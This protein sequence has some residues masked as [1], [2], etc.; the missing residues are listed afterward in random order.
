MIS[1]LSADEI[2]QIYRDN[3]LK[4]KTS[5]NVP[6]SDKDITLNRISKMYYES[7]IENYD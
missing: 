7:N 5:D 3:A 2:I 4:N 6:S 1:N